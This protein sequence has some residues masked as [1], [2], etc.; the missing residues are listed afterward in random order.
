VTDDGPAVLSEL[1]HDGVLVLTLSRPSRRNMWN[2]AMEEAYFDHLAAAADDPAVRAIVVTGAGSS[3][4]PGVDPEVLQVSAAGGVYQANRRPQ[5]LALSVPKPIIAAINGSVAG[6]GLVHALFTDYRFCDEGVKIATSF[7]KIGLPAEDGIA[8]VL[9]RLI[10]PSKTMDMLLTSRVVRSEE[11]LALGMIDRLTAPGTVLGEARSYAAALAASTS[12]SSMAMIKAQVY[13][14]LSST[15]EQAR[16]RALHL[17]TVAKRQPDFQEGV[18][19]LVERRPPQ[20]A[21]PTRLYL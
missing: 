4:C 5:T 11:A 19:A 3:F 2:A 17:L 14:D 12:P 6:L 16:V 21:A 13:A 10:G 7:A 18:E 15:L 9:S 20:F 1:G 8:W